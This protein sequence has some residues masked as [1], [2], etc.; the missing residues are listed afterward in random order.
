MSG[1]DG[2]DEE[3]AVDQT[4]FPGVQKRMLPGLEEAPGDETTRRNKE[5]KNLV[6]EGKWGLHPTSLLRWHFAD[7]SMQ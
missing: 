1:S 3:A 7:P 4:E 2:G 6:S 5:S